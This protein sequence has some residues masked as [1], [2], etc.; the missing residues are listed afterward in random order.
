MTHGHSEEAP[1]QNKEVKIIVNAREKTV[2]GKE[3]DFRSVVGLA[4]DNPVFDQNTVY[5]VTFVKGD[6]SKKEG[7]LTDG[8][9]VK[10]KD[11]M[12]FSVTPTDKS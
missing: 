2:I 1:G 5:T 6:A 12:V 11:G 7:T 3:V 9:T 8:D 10:L 4:F